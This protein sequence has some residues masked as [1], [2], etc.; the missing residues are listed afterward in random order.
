MPFSL[1]SWGFDIDHYLNRIIPPSPLPNLPYPIAHWFGYR[2]IPPKDV[3]NIIAAFFAFVGAFA[4][5][6]T[7]AGLFDYTGIRHLGGPVLIASFVCIVFS[8]YL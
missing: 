6:L 7:V 8:P 4:G 3:G 5:L 2:K 1:R